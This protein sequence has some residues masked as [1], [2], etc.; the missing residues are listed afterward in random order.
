MVFMAI[1]SYNQLKFLSLV[2]MAT[3][4]IILKLFLMPTKN[5]VI[6]ILVLGKLSRTIVVF[7]ATKS[8][9]QLKSLN[10]ITMATNKIV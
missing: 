10:L 2:T 6:E 5:V 7:M 1:K 9:N 8:Y 4:K 3:N